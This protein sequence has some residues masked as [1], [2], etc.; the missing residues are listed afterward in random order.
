MGGINAAGIS[1]WPI[2]EEVKMAD[3]LLE[4]WLN[5]R[6][7]TV[8]ENWSLGFVDG[9]FRKGGIYNNDPLLQ[10][11]TGLFKPFDNVKKRLVISS[12]NVNNG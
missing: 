7:R 10:Y 2:G 6:T 5:L 9:F 12:M 1:L 4:L 8:Y 11:L 3:W